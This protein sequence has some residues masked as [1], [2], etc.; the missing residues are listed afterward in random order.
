M[1]NIPYGNAN[2]YEIRNDDYIYIDRTS[3][4]RTLEKMKIT[5]PLFIR[6]RRFG[7]SLWLNILSNYYDVAKKDQFEFL[8]GEL[9]IGKNPTSDHN[10]YIVINWNFSR[11]SP[12]G[13]TDDI[14]AKM[15]NTLNNMME[16]GLVYYSNFLQ[17]V[18]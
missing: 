14:E 11:I 5:R 9:D 13:T 6:P 10:K 4:I 2:F 12:R 18:I 15:N 1:K 3:Y 8:F 7:K 16:V 17:K